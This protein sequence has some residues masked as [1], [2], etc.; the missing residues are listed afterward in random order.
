MY[1]CAS[2]WP[3]AWWGPQISSQSLQET[4]T[5]GT[6][7]VLGMFCCTGILSKL[8]RGKWSVD[9]SGLNRKWTNWNSSLF[10]GLT[11]EFTVVKFKWHYYI[12]H[13]GLTIK[14]SY[15]LLP[16]YCQTEQKNRCSFPSR[17]K[18]FLKKN[19][20][21]PS[22]PLSEFNVSVKPTLRMIS[23][24]IATSPNCSKEVTGR[25]CKTW[26]HDFVPQYI[27]SLW[28]A[29]IKVAPIILFK[30]FSNRFSKLRFLKLDLHFLPKLLRLYLQ[31]WSHVP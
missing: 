5:P 10:F 31:V 16:S 4:H 2:P 29:D 24:W 6:V 9:T 12:T 28:F 7:L 15:S 22:F 30:I 26:L 19:S 14:T 3:E 25:E 13:P 21:F 1:W 11:G 23:R 17:V 27:Y 8:V 18:N 20:Y